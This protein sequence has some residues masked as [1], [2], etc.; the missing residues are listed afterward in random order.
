MGVAD[1]GYAFCEFPA[2]VHQ[3]YEYGGIDMVNPFVGGVGFCAC[4]RG[5]P[6][7]VREGSGEEGA[8]SQ[9]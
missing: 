1:A 2:D 5:E 7:G 8:V 9:V 4:L 6:E 3:L